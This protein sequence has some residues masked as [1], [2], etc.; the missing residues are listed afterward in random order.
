[1]GRGRAAIAVPA[2]SANLGPGFDAMGLA[3]ELRNVYRFEP[4]PYDVIE[5][6][7]R[8]AQ[9]VP[10]DTGRNLAFRAFRLIAPPEAGPYRLHATRT[11]PGQGGLGSSGSSIIGGLA[12]A[13]FAFDLGLGDDELLRH[14]IKLEGHADNVAPAL[15]GGLIVI[16]NRPDGPR[17]VRLTLPDSLGLV[18]I[19]PNYRVP[20]GRAR[21]ALPDRVSLQDA[22]ANSSRAAMLVAALA[23]EQYHLLET[24]TE[25]F[26]HQ[27]YR[28]ALNPALEPCINAALEAEAYG[29]A[30][31]GSGP[32]IIAFTPK[33]QN[34]SVSSAMVDACHDAGHACETY[35][36]GPALTGAQTVE[37]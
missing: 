14:A 26:L 24:A 15:L 6:S 16:V 32:T 28:K 19:V 25:D 13:N 17:W 20:T 36:V 3:L 37:L 12:A 1:M 22:V 7:G 8:F 10:N 11:I 23:Q 35:V 30:L 2:S 33:E 9:F 21:A 31:S 5:A 18:L 4:A 29:A 34:I 27:P